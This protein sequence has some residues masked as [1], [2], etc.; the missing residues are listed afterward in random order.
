MN[1][2]IF[3]GA[4]LAGKSWLM[5]QV[6][7]F[8]EPKY[9]Q[10]K[11][12]LDGCH[13]F[14]CDV[15]VFGTK[16]GRKI[17]D[18]YLNIFDELKNKNILV[19]KLHIS[20]IVYNRLHRGVEIDYRLQE[21]ILNKLNFKIVLIVF[22]EDKDLLNK[23]IQDR[24]K[25]YPHYERILRDPDWYI[26]Q[27]REYL[28]EIEKTKLPSLIIETKTLPDPSLTEKILTWINEK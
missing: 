1:H 12:L 23:R 24:L 14:N 18:N 25:L 15:G 27:Q 13:W 4:E 11:V 8:L 7:D 28:K 9:N 5:S 21:D 10:G 20:D 26:K 2:L 22:P 6:Y 17:I 3:E 16:H 19:E